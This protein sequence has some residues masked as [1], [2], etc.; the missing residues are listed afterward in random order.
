[1]EFMLFP[2]Q[3]PKPRLFEIA[4]ARER[5]PDSVLVHHDKRNAIGQRP[6]LIGTL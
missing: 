4:D 6:F 3:R 1:M 2:Q 5:L